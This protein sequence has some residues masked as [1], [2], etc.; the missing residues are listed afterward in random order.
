[1]TRANAASYLAGTIPELL[2]E[3][4]LGNTDVTGALKEPIDMALMSTGV[5]YTGLAAATVTDSDVYGFLLALE[6]QALQRVR[7]VFV[8][9]A[10]DPDVSGAVKIAYT[11][12]IAAIDFRLA[13]LRVLAAPYIVDQGSCWGTGTITFDYLEPV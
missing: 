8:V 1:M 5:A 2:T 12:R 13:E 11:K 9:T 3:A 7:A 4:V 6:L 10:Y